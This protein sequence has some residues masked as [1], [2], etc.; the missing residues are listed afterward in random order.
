MITKFLQLNQVKAWLRLEPEYTEEDQLLTL[1]MINAES[2]IKRSITDFDKK[3]EN[4][5]ARASFILI[6]HMLIVDWYENRDFSGGLDEKLRHSIR[7][8]MLQLE[9]GA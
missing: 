8:I 7:S 6:S 1:L 5:D 3:L 4:E 9:L 2:Y